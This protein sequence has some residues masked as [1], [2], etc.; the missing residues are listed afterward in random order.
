MSFDRA[1]VAAKVQSGE[2][3]LEQA[4][5][6]AIEYGIQIE[7]NYQIDGEMRV[8]DDWI[9]ALLSN[10]PAEATSDVIPVFVWDVCER[11]MKMRRQQLAKDK[12]TGQVWGAPLGSTANGVM[13]Q[14]IATPANQ[15]TADVAANQIGNVGM[16]AD[17]DD[18]PF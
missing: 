14:S 2:L 1:E 6:D 15:I 9:R 8:R 10:V 16:Q 17:H 13:N 18:G 7:S 4:L 11:L 12:R 3:S 5:S